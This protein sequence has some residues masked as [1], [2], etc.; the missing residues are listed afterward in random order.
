[1]HIMRM[2]LLTL[3]VVAC[4]PAD[5]ITLTDGTVLDGEIIA[6][7]TDE[8]AVQVGGKGMRAV[9][10][11]PRTQVQ[12]ISRGPSVKAKA[13]AALADEA[14]NL[15]T[16]GSAERW[17]ELARGALAV[18][19][20]QAAR[21][22]AS[23]AISRDRHLA[24]PRAILDQRL[25]NGVWMNA[26]EAALASG[27]LWH[28]GRWMS[29]AQRQATIVETQERVAVLRQRGEA[30]AAARAARQTDEETPWPTTTMV[31]YGDDCYRWPARFTNVYGGA[32]A[33]QH[34]FTDQ[35]PNSSLRAWGQSNHVGWAL[36]WS[37]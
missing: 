7:T 15:G 25:V 2:F 10:H 31:S 26:G 11:L 16:G 34:A 1:M 13:L 22:W 19:D 4:L 6:E 5:E 23:Q 18:G 3:L 8:V 27:L 14:R 20:R 9:R 33:G 12:A 32:Y 30:L 29:Y 37:W 17:A 36:N 28:D 24:A 35:P 21:A